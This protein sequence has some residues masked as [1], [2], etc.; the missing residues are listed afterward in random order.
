MPLSPQEV[1]R[2]VSNFPPRAATLPQSVGRVYRAWYASNMTEINAAIQSLE[3]SEEGFST[4]SGSFSKTAKCRTLTA[5]GVTPEG[6]NEPPLE[7]DLRSMLP[8]EE[9]GEVD[10]EPAPVSMDALMARIHRL[11]E[12]QTSN[13]AT[14]ASLRRMQEDQDD[15]R[16]GAYLIAQEVVDAVP[17]SWLDLSVMSKKDRLRLLRDHGGVFPE[18]C[19]PAKLALHDSTKAHQE[20]K[21]AK[22]ISLEQFAKETS[23]FIDRVSSS[24]KFAGTVWSRIFEFTDDIQ[25]QLCDDPK[26]VWTGESI[27]AEV[28]P[29]MEAAHANFL[30]GLD[31]AKHMQLAVSKKV[32]TA[33]GIDHLR[34]DE[35]KKR[36]DDFISKDTY[37]L[38]E[39]AA[40]AKQ[41]LSWAKKGIFPGSQLGH[42]SRRPFPK[43]PG[44]GD[45]KSGRSSRRGR[46]GGKGRGGRGR[47]GGRGR[48]GRGGRSGQTGSSA[49][50]SSAGGSSSSPP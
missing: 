35:T 37:K 11:E 40:K 42:F 14:I 21:K 19:W 20:M 2:V 43:S 39:Q 25:S 1:Q 9:D 30:F 28:N 23:G 41:D 34:V 17:S 8:D 4:P 47:S 31:A 13:R 45:N 50:Q 48:G 16:V 6:D 26:L 18:G 15:D 29:I 5:H 27:L 10:P 32:D 22:T 38:V 36:H 7:A 46:G 33:L 44:S 24:T 49:S 12:E 3:E